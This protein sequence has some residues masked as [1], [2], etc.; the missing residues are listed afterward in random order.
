MASVAA[1]RLLFVAN[2]SR[3][4]EKIEQGP[5]HSMRKRLVQRMKRSRSNKS[6]E[7]M[8]GEEDKLPAIPSATLTGMKTFNRRNHRAGGTTTTVSNVDFPEDHEMEPMSKH[9]IYVND[10]VE[11]RSNRVSLENM[12]SLLL[13]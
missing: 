5:S 1:F 8:S 9:Q 10:N 11:V 12:K 7:A 6:W 4:A 2:S 3:A 13:F